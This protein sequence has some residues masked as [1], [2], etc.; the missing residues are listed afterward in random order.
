[1]QKVTP[2]QSRRIRELESKLGERTV[3]QL[4]SGSE[5]RLLDRRRFHN[6]TGGNG[7]MSASDV[8]RLQLIS[9]NSNSLS[10][11]KKRGS[12]KREYQTNRAM[13]TWLTKGKEKS[14]SGQSSDD[15][16]DTIH[17]LGFLGVDPQDGTFYVKKES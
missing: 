8:E 5:N 11:L 16:R 17:A 12:G 1:M 7:K 2:Q 10:A 15:K 9:R 13:R 14:V 4:L 3:R 6:L